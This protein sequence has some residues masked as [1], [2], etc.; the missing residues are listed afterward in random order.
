MEGAALPQVGAQASVVAGAGNRNRGCCWMLPVCTHHTREL[1]QHQHEPD[2]HAPCLPGTTHTNSRMNVLLTLPDPPL[3]HQIQTHKNTHR[4]LLALVDPSPA[5]RQLAEYL[6]RDVLA[7]KAPLLAYN[8]FVEAIFVLNGCTAGL[9]GARLGANLGGS[10]GG[11]GGSSMAAARVEEGGDG[12]GGAGVGEGE[13]G[14]AGDGLSVA[15]PAQFTLKGRQ[16]RW[17]CWLGVLL[18]DRLWWPSRVLR[19]RRWCIKV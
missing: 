8:H 13:T 5:V 17:V 6:L 9:H 2:R 11:G 14:A 12:S 3:P 15:A 7:V 4:F 19:M 18:A 16:H 10:G 1:G